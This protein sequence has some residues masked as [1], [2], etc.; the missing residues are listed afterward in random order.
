MEYRAVQDNVFLRFR[1]RPKTTQ[2]GL[3][4]IP[5]T[6]QESRVGVREAEVLMVGPG[7]WTPQ[8]KFIPTSVKVGEIVLVDAL[9][10]QHYDLDLSVPRH[11]KPTEWA[12]DKGQFRVVREDEIL[13]VI[14]RDAEAAE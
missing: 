3:L 9:A 6:V 14:E 10:G 11:N 2:T 4:H 13:G 12:D 7:H 5:E 1:P 8:G